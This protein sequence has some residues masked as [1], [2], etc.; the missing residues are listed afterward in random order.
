[1]YV[2]VSDSRAGLPGRCIPGVML[3]L[4][5]VLMSPAQTTSAQSPVLDRSPRKAAALSLVLPGLGHR[6]AHGGQWTNTASLLAI[7]D[8]S[9]WLGLVGT[10]RHRNQAIDSYT[11]LASS[12]AGADVVGKDRRFFLNLATYQSSDD[13][14]ETALRNRAWDQLSYVDDA[15]F[16]W[17]WESDEDFA[18]YRDLRNKSES[19][20]RRRS[21]L[22]AA[23]VTNRLISTISS[24]LVARR[25]APSNL[26]VTT[27][28]SPD[29]EFT[30]R[31]DFRF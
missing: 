1:M 29:S 28:A 15:S 16:Q 17:E 5:V 18:A 26:A 6:Y 4:V 20:K 13:F 25:T 12:R 21:I 22:I 27:S 8:V 19:L 7:A 2:Q 9:T 31:V 14:L 3:M 11:L 23:V 24:V 10:N 30:L